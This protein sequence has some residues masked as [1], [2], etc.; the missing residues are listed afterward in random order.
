MLSGFAQSVARGEVLLRSVLRQHEAAFRFIAKV[1]PKA[2][3][4]DFIL[5][6]S[7]NNRIGKEEIVEV[8]TEL[9]YV[10]WTIALVK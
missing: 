2:A 7:R 8:K 3:L 5:V 10:P 9:G 1:P 4:E 6:L